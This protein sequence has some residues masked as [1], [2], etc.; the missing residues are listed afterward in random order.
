MITFLAFSKPRAPAYL[1]AVPAALAACCERK[2]PGK[3]SPARPS[4]PIRSSSRRVGPSQV[5]PAIRPGIF[6]TSASFL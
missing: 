6:S 4:E 2:N 1:F 3:C 5:C